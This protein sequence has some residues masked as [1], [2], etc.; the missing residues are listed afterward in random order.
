M[1]D[2]YAHC[3]IDR[4]SDFFVT[5]V[6]FLLPRFKSSATK[7]NIWNIFHVNVCLSVG[8]IHKLLSTCLRGEIDR[9]GRNISRI[10][11]E[12]FS[13]LLELAFG[14]NTTSE[15]NTKQFATILD[16][17]SSSYFKWTLASLT[18]T[19]WNGF[20][21]GTNDKQIL[22]LFGCRRQ[23]LRFQ[24]DCQTYSNRRRAR[25]ALTWDCLPS[26]HTAKR[27]E[28]NTFLLRFFV[29]SLLDSLNIFSTLQCQAV[30]SPYD[31][32]THDDFPPQ[33]NRHGENCMIFNC[34]L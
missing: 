31:Y 32:S 5:A 4:H 25:I 13:I 28:S 15:T 2:M 20:L 12:I 8:K 10:K 27:N 21:S 33:Q 18:R 30:V 29:A 19:E 3:S 6:T 34:I 9:G 23:L 24:S 26:L 14:Q 1:C 7:C 17:C 22:S 11:I 16:E